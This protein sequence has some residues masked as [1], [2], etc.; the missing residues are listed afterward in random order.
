MSPADINSRIGTV[1]AALWC[2]AAT[3]LTVAGCD[4]IGQDFNALT[5]SLMPPTPSEA[6]ERMVDPNDPDNRRR[7]TLLIANSPFGGADPYLKVYRDMAIHERD[8]LA[9]AAALS[10]LGRHG[11]PNDA[12][13]IAASLDDENRQVRWAAA[14]ALQRIHNVAV[15]GDLLEVLRKDEEY[16]DTRIAA[17]VALGQY[18]QDRVFQGLISALDER[19]LALN[20]AAQGSLL[21]LTG[22]DFGLEPSA[23]LGWYNNTA[24][25]FAGRQEYLYPT[26]QRDE[27]WME[28]LAFWST[29]TYEQPA[30]PAGLRPES[31]RRTYEDDDELNPDEPG[32]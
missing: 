17:A 3:V 7:G 25:P 29:T 10:A 5:E 15:T 27:T 21:V 13:V 8:P 2:G 31:E 11:L 23:W 20:F 4:T 28:R 6:V 22:Q 12:P 26:Y 30:P 18:P 19:E 24:E 9:K 16:A 14:Q 1:A 32:G